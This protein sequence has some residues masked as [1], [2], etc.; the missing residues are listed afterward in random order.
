MIATAMPET[1]LLRENAEIRAR[2]EE[3]EEA[4]RAIRS[5]EVD[6]LVVETEGGPK[7][8]IL[9]SSD[10]DSNRFRSDILSKVS[11]AVV[12]VDND[13][14]LVFINAA[15]EKQY[16]VDSSQV[17]G[18][19]IE[20]IYQT[21]WPGTRDEEDFARSL[22]EA[23]HW[24]GESIHVKRGG[25]VVH[26]ETSVSRLT[27]K[28]GGP[29]GL[30]GVIRDITDR[31]TAEDAEVRNEVLFSTIINQS[32]G[33][34]YVVDDGFRIY[35]ASV[36]AKSVLHAA[37]PLVGRDLGE[38][39]RILWGEKLGSE[40][41]VI[42]RHTLET[43]EPYFAPRFS[44]TRQD[45]QGERAYDW[46]IQ[47]ISLPNGKHGVVCYF[48]DITPQRALED[49]LVARSADLAQADR[50]KDEF[51]AMLAHE[52]RNPLAPMR[53]AAEILRS[54]AVPEERRQAQHIIDRQIENMSR[55][56]DDL[57]D[58][59][60]I[61]EGKI[62]LKKEKVELE[63]ILRSAA[64]LAR[65]GCLANGQ[66]LTVTY[67]ARRVMLLADATRLE[68]VFGNLLSNACKYGGAGCRVW[69]SAA[70]D[71]GGEKPE[72]VVSV[73][74]DGVGILPELLP[75]IFDL[76]VQAS[77]TIDRAH[78]GL[79]IG[80]TLVQRL[81]TLHGGRIEARSDGGGRGS[82]FL[83]RLPVLDG[84]CTEPPKTGFLAR[85]DKPRRMLI[86]DDNVD[87]AESMAMLQQLRGHDTRT[88]HTGPAAVELAAAFEP[89]VVLLDIGLPGMDGYQVARRVRAMPGMEKVFLVAMTGYGSDEDRRRAKEAGFD[90]HMAK[91][92]DLELL[93]EWLR[94][95]P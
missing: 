92:A 1:H 90:E 11:D 41:A 62:E 78:G 31:K 37:E 28:D 63:E 83:V 46:Q 30:L 3:S 79:G 93:R 75:R 88:A 94:A 22:S 74:D 77:R 39:L 40:L 19:R 32:P 76:F 25:Q 89:E 26:V 10:A 13:D 53:N 14:R 6:G 65:P 60:R 7:L 2:L 49:K 44:A 12:A 95:R 35:Q 84:S 24:R 54:T 18:C 45:I 17:L 70:L 29:S 21:R 27:A 68:Q 20:E 33:G 91:P 67:P 56:I 36:Q 51:L 5:G 47:Q 85:T 55:M 61:T 81:V 80:L 48:S 8:F 23:G 59:S 9:Q 73:R 87:A 72:V 58:V 57:L 69:L 82:E 52:L 4:L 66:Q 43:G 38:V 34:I 42:Y 15:A 50:A 86:V 64:N 71:P 16:G